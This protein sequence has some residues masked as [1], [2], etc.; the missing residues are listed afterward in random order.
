MYKLLEVE[1]AFRTRETTLELKPVYHGMV[2]GSPGAF[3]LVRIS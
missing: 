2:T 3:M 1:R